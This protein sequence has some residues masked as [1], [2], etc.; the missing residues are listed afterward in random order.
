MDCRHRNAQGAGAADHPSPQCKS[1]HSASR[2]HTRLKHVG[3]RLRLPPDSK[4]N[5]DPATPCEPLF[6]TSAMP[7]CGAPLGTL[8]F[9]PRGGST[10]LA[11]HA[12]DEVGLSEPIKDFLHAVL[13]CDA[14]QLS[15]NSVRDYVV[16]LQVVHYGFLWRSQRFMFD[17]D[18]HRVLCL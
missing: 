11:W 14:R 13:R 7:T 6:V 2:S 8:N 5:S 1:R 4:A 12:F 10:P 15:G 3:R 16:I 17:S 9:L 18:E